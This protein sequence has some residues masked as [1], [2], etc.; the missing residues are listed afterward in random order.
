MHGLSPL[1]S[2]KLILWVSTLAL[3]CYSKALAQNNWIVTLENDY[4]VYEGYSIK[5]TEDGKYIVAGRG[6]DIYNT[7]MKLNSNGD[8]IWDK[9][10]WV[11]VGVYNWGHLYDVVVLPNNGGYVAVG[12]ISDNGDLSA[13][14][15]RYDTAGNVM[16]I[17]SLQHSSSTANEGFRAVALSTT[18][19]LIAVGYTGRYG[20]G[21]EALLTEWDL[22]GNLLSAYT[23]GGS[24][25]DVFHSV[26][27]AQNGDIILSGR[28]SFSGTTE[29]VLLMRLSPSFA[30]QWA[31]EF[32]IVEHLRARAIEDANGD[33]VVI[34]NSDYNI[35][36]LDMYLFKFSG[37]GT[38]ITAHSYATSTQDEYPRDI[39]QVGNRYFIVGVQNHSVYNERGLVIVTDLSGN[40]ITSNVLEH[41]DNR[42]E[43]RF[44]SVFNDGDGTVTIT[45]KYDSSVFHGILTLKIDD[46]GDL[47][48]CNTAFY[49]TGVSLA[50]TQYTT[51]AYENSLPTTLTSISPNVITYSLNF[52]N[53]NA[54]FRV[55]SDLPPIVSASINHVSCRG[56]STGSITL[57]VTGGTPPH[58]IVWNTGATGP[59]ITNLSAGTYVATI[60]Y[61][62]G[63][64]TIVDTFVVTE[65]SVP[66]PSISA[67]VTHVSCHGSS[68]GVIDITVSGGQPPILFLGIM[69]LLLRTFQMSLRA[70]TLLQSLMLM[71]V[72]FLKHFK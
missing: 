70:H 4:F 2:M 62:S 10:F 69:V 56:A 49:T 33:I 57:V 37:S 55:R 5:K 34:A 43:T 23:Y 11:S 66:P 31:K 35:G 28:Y 58:S 22:N 6:Q 47:N 39:V 17:K 27:I 65:P 25:S 18:N 3:L 61:G 41:P 72:L 63:G 30:V 32:S 71:G 1:N 60:S 15:V 13:I 8:F 20:N 59:S 12:E 53:V 54:T 48:A 44:Y 40:L 14:I 42:V 9:H 19:T 36:D 50:D 16:W 64:C 68:D 51:L 38:F 52:V 24:Y 29:N 45:G 26:E 67:S 46:S 7:L 21:G